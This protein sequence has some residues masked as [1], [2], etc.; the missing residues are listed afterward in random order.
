[1]RAREWETKQ[2]A[3]GYLLGASDL[4]EAQKWLGDMHDHEP[5]PTAL[6]VEYISASQQWA[7]CSNE[8]SFVNSTSAAWS[9]RSV[10]IG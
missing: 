3:P 5:A 9:F 2:K 8:D 7:T 1:V 10:T 6:H 4:D